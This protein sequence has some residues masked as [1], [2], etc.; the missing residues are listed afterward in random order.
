MATIHS[1]SIISSSAEIGSDVWIGPFC[2]VGDNVKIKNSTK[3]ISH[4]CIDGYTTIGKNCIFY[5]FSSIGFNPQDLKYKG[6]KSKL[7]IGNN[8]IVRENVTINTGTSG[9]GMITKIG[10]DCLMMI[11]AHIA[12]DCK[13]GNNVILVNNASLA[14]H[15]EVGDFAILGALS[16]VHQFCRI[17]AHSMIGGLSGVDSDVIP[18][19]TV[20]GNRAYLS[21][22]NIS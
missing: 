9:G 16:G 19:G 5:P 4:V 10:N 22:L 20:M 3:L 12:H 18:Y 15:V 8:N 7:I 17:G 1:S 21:S 11:G 6:E 2:T 14:G 13:I